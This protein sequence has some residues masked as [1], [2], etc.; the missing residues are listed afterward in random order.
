VRRARHHPLPTRPLIRRRRGRLRPPLTRR[1]PLRTR[2]PVDLSTP[3]HRPA[4]DDRPLLRHR[5]RRLHPRPPLRPS[6]LRASPL[7][8]W[9]HQITGED[10]QWAAGRRLDGIRPRWSRRT[11]VVVST[12]HRGEYRHG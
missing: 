4:V 1:R 10:G 5:H 3:D 9:S 7:A 8:Q 2:P 12:P 11:A 6:T